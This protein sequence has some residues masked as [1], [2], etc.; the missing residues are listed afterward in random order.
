MKSKILGFLAASLVGLPMTTLASQIYVIDSGVSGHSQVQAAKNHLAATGH[1]VTAGATLGDY[2]VYDQVWDLR[3]NANLGAPDIAAMQSYLQG[4]GR[5]YLTGEH[6]GFD[7]RNNSLLAWITAV[8]GGTLALDGTCFSGNSPITAAGQVV[9]S[10]N[11]LTNVSFGCARTILGSSILS[12][13]AVT[14]SNALI[15][16]N[17]GD[18]SGAGAARMLVGFDIEIFG[19]G[20]AWTENMAAFLGAPGTPVPEPGTLALLGLGLAGLGL[21][22]RRKA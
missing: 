9:N 17:F 5:M 1:T 20:Q 18:I 6:S 8:G 4:G 22:R 16:W 21:N 3:Y 11:G 10:P 13:F 2:S 19:T 15:G 14:Q 12:G 7:A